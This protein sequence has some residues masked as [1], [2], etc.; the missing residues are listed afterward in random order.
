MRKLKCAVVAIVV[1]FLSPGTLFAAD[2][3]PGKVTITH[4][5]CTEEPIK[6]Q[7]G[8][9]RVLAKAPGGELGH[10]VA[11]ILACPTI[12]LAA[13]EGNRTNGTAGPAVDFALTVTDS[14]G[15]KQTLADADFVPSKL[16][17]TDM[18]QDANGDGKKSADICLDVSNYMFS[19]LPAGDLTI[20]ETTPPNGWKFGTMLLTPTALQP[21]GSDDAKT[22]A[23]F[24]ARTGTI[25]LDLAGDN[26][27]AAAVQIYLFA[28]SPATD[29]LQAESDGRLPAALAIGAILLVLL[30]A[31]FAIRGRTA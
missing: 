1:L 5:A 12:V 9:D 11:A 27:N 17:E 10:A 29:T 8:F 26:D 4:H 3:D 6:S 28:N 20:R 23:D 15:D 2:G 13:D 22:G 7:D 31:L 25:T 16:C 24:D 21:P 18:D 30:A 14:K 19:N